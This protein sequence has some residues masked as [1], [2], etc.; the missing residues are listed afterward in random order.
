[1]IPVLDDYNW[2]EV[3][4]Y[5]E[6]THTCGRCGGE[7]KTGG[8]ETVICSPNANTSSFTREDVD[9]IIAMVNGEP[10]VSSWVGVFLLKDGRCVS[11][12][13]GCDYTGWG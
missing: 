4:K 10:D 13:A 12:T 5:A 2:K 7:H 1:M 9:S 11:I 8:P 3:F 6:P